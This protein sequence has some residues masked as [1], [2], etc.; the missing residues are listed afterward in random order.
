M[1]PLLNESFD[2]DEVQRCIHVG[3]LC[4]EQFSN[5]RPT[6]SHII[7]ML[8]NKSNA[9]TLPRIP[10]FYAGKESNEENLSYEELTKHLF[11]KRNVYFL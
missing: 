5:D 3:L 9:F 2:P 8:T 7:S 6:M 10:A 1:D 4:V 11:Y